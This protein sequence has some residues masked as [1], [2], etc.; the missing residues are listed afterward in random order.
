MNPPGEYT[1]GRKTN[2]KVV[3]TINVLHFQVKVVKSL[4]RKCLVQVLRHF[5]K[6]FP[7][8]TSSSPKTA[9]IAESTSP[10]QPPASFSYVFS[11]PSFK[12]SLVVFLRCLLCPQSVPT[13][14]FSSLYLSSYS[15]TFYGISRVSPSAMTG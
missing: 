8:T 1:S 13:R 3:T 12:P 6:Y 15:H 4:K 11:P 10:S 2:A 14:D 5:R 9:W 7:E